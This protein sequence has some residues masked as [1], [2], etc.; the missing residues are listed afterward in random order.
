MRGIMLLFW[1][2][3]LFVNGLWAQEKLESKRPLPIMGW[4]GIPAGENNIGRFLELKEMG[5]NINLCNYANVEEM[6]KGLDLAQKA[7]IQMVTSCPELKSDPENTVK[8]FMHHP[9]LTGY[10]LRDEPVRKDFAELGEWVRKIEAIDSLHFCFVNLISSINLT[11]TEALGTKSYADYVSTFAKEVPSKLLSFDFY[12]I[13]TAGVHENWYHGLEVFSAEAK[14]MGKPMW[15]F[16]LAS[17]YNELHPIPTVAALRLQQY[18]NLAYGAQGLEYW[19]YWM[20]QG[21]RSA[22]IDLNGRRTVVYDR[23]KEVNKEI[24]SLAGVFVGSKVVSVRHT[25]VVIPKGTTR[26]TTLPYA[27][28]VIETEGSGA[29]VSTLENGENTFFVV[30]NRDLIESI[31]IVI[32]GD[33]SLK[34]V[35]KDGSVVSAKRY[36]PKL[37]IGPGDIAIYT[38]PTK[39]L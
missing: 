31:T 7:G 9:A 15:A 17:S 16:A 2:T 6:Q 19:S 30:V 28:K 27:I 11:Q 24:Q 5:I 4:S 35:L 38:F 18:S 12:P 23:I 37:E 20:S 39:K 3:G 10:F 33:D 34:R 36:D 22:P 25:G 8:K 32:Y 29:L 13:L 14:K 1:I 26:L 21:L